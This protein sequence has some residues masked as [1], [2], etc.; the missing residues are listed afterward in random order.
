MTGRMI[1]KKLRIVSWELSLNDQRLFYNQKRT[2]QNLGNRALKLAR[3]DS[4]LLTKTHLHLNFRGKEEGK[5]DRSIFEE[6]IKI[7]AI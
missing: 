2:P 3:D 4:A 6:I 5:L 7:S 1:L